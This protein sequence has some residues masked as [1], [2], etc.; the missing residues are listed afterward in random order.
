MIFTIGGGDMECCLTDG[1]D[2]PRKKRQFFKQ[3]HDV[4]LFKSPSADVL[5]PPFRRFDHFSRWFLICSAELTEESPL[6]LGPFVSLSQGASRE[7]R[8]KRTGE[9]NPAGV[10]TTPVLVAGIPITGDTEKR[11]FA[12]GGFKSA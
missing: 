6:E 3:I 11:D 10:F 9:M 12:K 7:K 1:K 4:L 5:F 2:V 8:K